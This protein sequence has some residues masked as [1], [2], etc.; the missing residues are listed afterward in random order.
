MSQV[1]LKTSRQGT[2]NLY[3][4][5]PK[6]YH[7]EALEGRE[8]ALV[9]GKRG[10]KREE[11]FGKKIIFTKQKTIKKFA[12]LATRAVKVRLQFYLIAKNVFK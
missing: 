6:M 4:Q 5:T 3:L 12:G 1:A 9:G 10:L 7:S 2:I 11:S 8:S